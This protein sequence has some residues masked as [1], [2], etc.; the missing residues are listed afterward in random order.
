MSGSAPT[1]NN[2]FFPYSGVSYNHVVHPTRQP[3][4]ELRRSSSDVPHQNVS[5]SF[6]SKL[7]SHIR[8]TCFIVLL[9]RTMAKIART[10]C[11]NAA[12]HISIVRN[13]AWE[14]FEPSITPSHLLPLRNSPALYS[15]ER[16]RS[17]TK[18]RPVPIGGYRLKITN[19]FNDYWPSRLLQRI[20]LYLKKLRS[21]GERSLSP[22]A[23]CD[24]H[25]YQIDAVSA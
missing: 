17:R 21:I 9:P 5:K 23:A 16:N 24:S 3:T 25:A 7:K 10:L 4:W 22:A 11:E 20:A 14:Y 8:T 6:A 18:V 1:R 2:L 13:Y 12:Q 19:R 15:R